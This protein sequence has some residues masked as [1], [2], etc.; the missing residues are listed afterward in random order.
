MDVV[1]RFLSAVV[2]GEVDVVRSI[3]HPE[4]VV[5]HS[6]DGVEQSVDQN[7]AVLSWM[8]ANLPGF[9]YDNVR[10]HPIP[11]GVVEQHDTLIPLPGTDETLVM[12][13]CL[14]IQVDGDGRV[15]RLDEYLDGKAV[16]RL[17]AAV[18]A[19]AASAR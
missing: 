1:G 19:F 11:G 13:A 6:D 2:A 3:Y 4:A 14:V 7:L 10:R 15:T 9:G 17:V 18:T 8:A 16:E 12:H 5:W